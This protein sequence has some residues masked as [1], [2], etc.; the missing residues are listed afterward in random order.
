MPETQQISDRARFPATPPE[1]LRRFTKIAPFAAPSC[2]P[3]VARQFQGRKMLLVE[4]LA[5]QAGV[6]V[7]TIR[8]WRKLYTL[9]GLAALARASRADKGRP[10]ALNGAATEFLLRVL[11]RNPQ[12]GPFRPSVASVYRAYQEERA[13]RAAHIGKALGQFELRKLAVWADGGVLRLDSAMPKLS[14]E[15]LRVWLRR[16]P[17]LAN[18]FLNTPKGAKGR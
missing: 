7:R 16:V 2:F 11:L 9:G 10:R 14:Y 8:R 12:T 1:A 15:T 13:W 17:E 18:F 6:S 5:R 3:V 4:T